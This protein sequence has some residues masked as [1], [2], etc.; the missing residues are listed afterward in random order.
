MPE[1][2][3]ERVRRDALKARHERRRNDQ[4]MRRKE[5]RNEQTA[6]AAR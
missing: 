6:K 1:L 2:E 4:D 5:A 3:R